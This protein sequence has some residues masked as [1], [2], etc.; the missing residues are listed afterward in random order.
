MGG[1]ALSTILALLVTALL[2]GANALY[3]FH[4]FAFVTIRQTDVRKIERS[5][6][7][8]ARLVSRGVHRLDHYIAVDQLGITITSIAVG[9]IGQPVV[10][11]LLGGG[12]AGMGVLGAG[13]AAAIGGGLAFALITAVQMVAGELMPKTVALRHPVR[14]ASLVAL[15]V[16]IT[17][18]VMHPVVVLLN[19][20]GGLVVRLFGLEPQAESHTQQLPPEELASLI[21]ASA[22]A[23]TLSVDPAALRRAL[24]FSD[25]RAHDMMVPRQ[26]V[27]AIEVTMP[28]EEVLE[29]GR[30]A[31]HT[32]YPVYE[33]DMD[34][35]VGVLNIKDLV[36]RDATGRPT[37]VD[38]WRPLVRPVPILPESVSVEGLLHQLRREKRQLAV[39]ADEYGGTAGIV[40]VTAVADRLMGAHDEEIRQTRDGEHVL[41]G[42]ANIEEV[43][44]ALGVSLAP[45]ERDYETIGGLVMARTGD[46]PSVG[47]RVEVN[48][49]AITVSAMD[50]MRVV[51]VRLRLAQPPSAGEDSGGSPA[52]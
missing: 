52:D 29:L 27:A 4:E 14:V 49:H 47:D 9:W 19:G 24:R 28:L 32:R 20:A 51:E 50:G 46:I 26:N 31:R 40:T 3:V 23:G 16:E 34:T 43:E 36:Q 33:G 25:L 6:S 38:D 5:R 21:E 42:Q 22:R 10:A 41:E 35:V 30:R 13:V 45:E 18:K 12:L 7:R 11:L 37:V 44:E 1:E 2:I 48:G 8:I 15:P 17:A 39:L